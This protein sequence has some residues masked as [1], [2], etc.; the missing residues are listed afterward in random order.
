MSPTAPASPNAD[1]PVNPPMLTQP[2]SIAGCAEPPEAR[3][4]KKVKGKKAKD[5]KV[6]KETEDKQKVETPYPSGISPR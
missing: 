1:P 3:L 6:R 5:E 2:A 4:K